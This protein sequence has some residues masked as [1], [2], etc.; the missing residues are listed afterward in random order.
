MIL[1]TEAPNVST[2]KPANLRFDITI[3]IMYPVPM[4]EIGR[5]P[6]LVAQSAFKLSALRS[7]LSF[8]TSWPTPLTVGRMVVDNKALSQLVGHQNVSIHPPD[9]RAP[10]V[11]IHIPKGAESL[12]NSPVSTVFKKILTWYIRRTAPAKYHDNLVPTYPPGCKRLVL[13]SNY[14]AALHQPNVD[15]NWT[16]IQEFVEDGIVLKTGD[17][18]FLSSSAMRCFTA[19][20][21]DITASFDNLLVS[22]EPSTTSGKPDITTEVQKHG[23]VWIFGIPMLSAYRDR[24]QASAPL[25]NLWEE[26]S[27]GVSESGGCGDRR[28]DAF[29]FSPVLECV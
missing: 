21:A 26:T 10:H 1:L 19:S 12:A 16:G 6:I 24:N 17:M 7:I 14:L 28:E 29:T 4:E 11:R 27:T 2:L 9:F 5:P 8:D 22:L 25:C 20:C 18:V 15:L 3:G 13:D 23:A